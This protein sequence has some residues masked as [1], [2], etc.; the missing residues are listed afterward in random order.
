MRPINSSVSLWWVIGGCGW[1]IVSVGE[2][3]AMTAQS[4]EATRRVRVDG[5]PGGGVLSLPALVMERREGELCFSLGLA[6]RW[7]FEEE[8]MEIP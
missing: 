6:G 4:I 5:K 2:A 7:L 3:F 8:A 1:V